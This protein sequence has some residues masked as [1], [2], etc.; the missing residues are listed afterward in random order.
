VQLFLLH[1]VAVDIMLLFFNI[2][3]VIASVL[4]FFVLWLSFTSNIYENAWEFGVLRAIGLSAN[5][6]IRVYIYEALAIIMSALV[7]GST[8]GILIAAT[9]TLQF[10]LFTEMRFQFDF[11]YFLFGSVVLL[12]LTVAVVGSYLASLDIKRQ[13]IAQTL[14]GGA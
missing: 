14:K 7:L 8:T 6:V 5:Q 4:C 9:L 3:S 10:N 2:V 13:P 12:S 11:P 1:S